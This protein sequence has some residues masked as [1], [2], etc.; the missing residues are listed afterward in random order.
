MTLPGAEQTAR[1][2][3]RADNG[4]TRSPAPEKGDRSGSGPDA[5]PRGG[6]GTHGFQPPPGATTHGQATGAPCP[7][8]GNRQGPPRG[9]ELMRGI[10]VALW[11]G[12]S[13]LAVPPASAGV[14]TEMA[15]RWTA[16]AVLAA[17]V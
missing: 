3:P 8:H 9:R 4:C 11:A 10:A 7:R 13:L 1:S 2:S 15:A 12:L 16:L 5:C 14:G 6:P 17:S